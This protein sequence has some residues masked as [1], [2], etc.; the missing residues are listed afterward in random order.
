MKLSIVLV[1]HNS[2]R[3]LGLALTSLIKAAKNIIHEIIVVD[4]ASADFSLEMLALEFQ[5]VYV[6][7]NHK[8][9]GLAK[10]YNQAMRLARGQYVL[11]ISPDTFSRMDSLEKMTFFMDQHTNA[12]GLSVRMVDRKGDYL[13]GSK[14]SLNS[15]W[16]SFMKFVGLAS[17]F[18]K[19]L[20]AHKTKDWVEEFETTE[21]DTLNENCM[22]LRR[23]ALNQVGLF[24][25]RFF[26]YGHNIDLSYRI[27][28]QG[29]KNYYYSK[30]YI[31]QLPGKYVNKFSWDHIRHFYGAMI[32]FAAKYLLK[33][34]VLNIKNIGELQPSSYE[35]E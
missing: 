23:S 34:P 9:E 17:Y 21:V 33:L 22:L 11:L 25:E 12:G 18:P 13:P 6:I 15:T 4:N 7:A 1:N 8:N 29:F 20:A 5:G 32:I 35:I 30:T 31:I 26:C 2:S 24:D 10:A 16:A 19:S 3:E 28:M 27:R 14:H